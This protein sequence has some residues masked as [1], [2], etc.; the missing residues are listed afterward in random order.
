MICLVMYTFVYTES[1]LDSLLNRHSWDI[2]GIGIGRSRSNAVISPA[3]NPGRSSQS[4]V[5]WGIPHPSTL[6]A[7]G[8]AS[9]R[10]ISVVIPVPI[11]PILP[12]LLCITV[13]TVLRNGGI[14]KLASLCSM[15][16]WKWQQ[17]YSIQ[18]RQKCYRC[19]I[20][21][22]VSKKQVYTIRTGICHGIYH[23]IY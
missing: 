18:S 7:A 21:W 8:T 17:L 3:S 19:Y 10:C 9:R 23:G 2:T 12:I 5:G 20:P 15:T 6:S 11:T 22:Y 14:H 16:I 13:H 4:S 1:Y